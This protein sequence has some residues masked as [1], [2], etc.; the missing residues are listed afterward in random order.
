MMRKDKVGPP[1]AAAMSRSCDISRATA[2]PGIPNSQDAFLPPD[3][4]M[5]PH[6]CGSAATS[7]GPI[8][9]TVLGPWRPAA[10]LLVLALV[11]C[12][13]L[14]GQQQQSQ[15]PQPPPTPSV[16]FQTSSNLVIE[17]V[18]VLDRSGT[19][20]EGL[21]AKDFAITE[22][23]V[24]QTISICEFQKIEEIERQLSRRPSPENPP[25]AVD[26]PKVEPVT[27]NQIL[28]EPPG[29]IRYRDRRLIALYFDMAG[30]S[31]PD[32][33][34]A[35]AS[36]LKFIEKQMQPA[37]LLAIFAFT[38][39]M[40]VLQDF[41]DDRDEIVKAVNKL[42]IGE[43]QGFDAIL[44]DASAADYGSAFGED[45]SEFNLFTTDRHLNALQTAVKMLGNLNEKKVLVYFASGLNLNGIGNQAQY[46]AT[47]NSA[48]KANV[49]FYPVDARG[50]IAMAPLGDA[51]R[52][53]PGGIGMYTGASAMAMVSAL[54]R[55]QDT[56]YAL[57]A[58]TGGK[59]LLD[60]NDLSNGIVN[61]QKAISSYYIIGY[62]TQ[63]TAL[64]GKFR[65]IK[66]A[67]D[68]DKS[69][70]LDYRVG[71]F[72]QKIFAKFNTA[73]K[74]RQLQDALMLEDPITEI[75][76]ALEID[77]FQLNG[78]EYYTSVAIKIPGSELALAKRGGSEHTLID[79]IGEVKD[80]YNV[81]QTNVRDTIDAKLTNETAAQLARHPV[82]YNAGF[83]LLPGIYTIKVLVRD[84][85]TGR[86][87][88]YKSR[89]T[90]PNLELE[91]KRI[92]ISSVILSSQRIDPREAIFTASK[93]KEPNSNPLLAGGQILIPSVNRV[94]SKGQQNLYVFLQAYRRDEPAEHPLVAYVTFY[95]GQTK[96]FE[97]TPMAVTEWSSAKLKTANLRFSIPLE[98]L[99][100]GRYACQV[101]VVDPIT[102][103]AAFWQ[104]PMLLAP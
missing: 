73:E 67:Y 95:R 20:V 18:S 46:A 62:Y 36:A 71:Y 14:S 39:T 93:D 5:N 81:T 42:F 19:P 78:A 77:Y 21:T 23:G 99:Q 63:N 30:M 8:K 96:A 56:L 37:D 49:S 52:G 48:L 31:P 98:K 15:A 24:P 100:T 101:T 28:P 102:Q 16:K 55:S 12:F 4:G 54:Q 57:A 32:Q 38:D 59:A 61:A 75:T 72:A 53:S 60:N 86:I 70:K 13:A 91:Q 44:Q 85:E 41:T 45:D 80:E 103:K 87:G 11:L 50:L 82:Q 3:G 34:R 43:A 9:L 66:I 51:T 94:F 2:R 90:I 33:Y 104:A 1:L 25:P 47:I 88:T 68:G 64:D 79:F 26:R 76:T 97:T 83:T 27:K 65:R 84:N 7:D 40:K 92:P 29:D 58:D 22:D 35:Q 69:A 10:G 6:E 89:F 74:E 17:T